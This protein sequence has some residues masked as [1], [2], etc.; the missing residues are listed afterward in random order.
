MLWGC[1]RGERSGDFVQVKGIMKK[2]NYH[3]IL[4]RHVIPS[5]LQIIG[6]SPF[7]NRTTI[8]NIHQN[9][10]KITSIQKRSKRF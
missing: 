6:K 9:Y 5:G 4:Q 2:E 8:Q 7:F 10:A 3:S 1:F